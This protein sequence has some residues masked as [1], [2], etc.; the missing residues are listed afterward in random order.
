MGV[1][2]R[3][4]K[5]L[6][7]KV[8]Q[9]TS[10][11]RCYEVPPSVGATKH[12]FEKVLRSTS[13]RRCYEAPL[14]HLFQNVLHSTLKGALFVSSRAPL[15]VLYRYLK[16]VLCPI[17]LATVGNYSGNWY[18]CECELLGKNH[19]RVPQRYCCCLPFITIRYQLPS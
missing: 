5:Y 16:S 9:S 7:E 15:K 18:L 10:F 12:L 14:K 11:K 6:F 13:S 19:C 17:Q 8:P 1:I 3:V 4:L 2:F